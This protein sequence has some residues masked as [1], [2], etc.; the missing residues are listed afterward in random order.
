MR[1]GLLLCVLVLLP[2]VAGAAASPRDVVRVCAREAMDGIK[3][4]Q[5]LEVACPEL[6]P[7]LDELGVTPLLSKDTRENMTAAMLVDATELASAHAARGIPDVRN[8]RPILSALSTRAPD[9]GWWARIIDWLRSHLGSKAPARAPD[10][11]KRLLDAIEFSPAVLVV[12]IYGL[13]AVVIGAAG[14]IIYRELQASGVLQRRAGR[15]A[16]AD[17]TPDAPDPAPLTLGG[18]ELLPAA[19]RISA[20]FRL[21]VEEVEASGGSAARAR[22]HRQLRDT[23]RLPDPESARRF[24][25]LALVAEEQLYAPAP[26]PVARLEAAIADGI[27]LYGS[28]A[29]RRTP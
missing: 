12:V 28:L 2:P 4:L 25:A 8:L 24:S 22:T 1:P 11:L 19:E 23:L 26:V 18:L 3:G 15:A 13:I 20:L 29:G 14:W 21:V 6:G 7:A 27:A 16:R 9:R 5:A 17:G 10:W